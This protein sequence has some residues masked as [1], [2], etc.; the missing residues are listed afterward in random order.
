MKEGQDA[1]YYI[2][3]EDKEAL[4]RSPQLEGFKAKGVEVLLF[5]DAV[6]DFSSVPEFQEKPFKS[7]T[8]GG[9]D[10]NN[11]AKSDDEKKDE[12]KP[13]DSE[14]S[15][16]VTF[17]KLVLT[18]EVKDV[19]SSER[20]TDSPVCLVA[21]DHDIDMHLARVLKQHKQLDESAKRILELNPQHALIKGLAEAI[22]EDSSSALAEDA[23]H[24]LLDQARILEGETLPDPGGFSRRLA[25]V[26]EKGFGA[27]D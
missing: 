15:A 12:D 5:T 21:D 17:V 2:S 1:I 6:D 13:D 9:A 3:G 25:A 20:L 11:I 24:L 23:A 16:L 22:G 26:M 18:D 10:L 27:S 7:V 14:I 8:R 19:R 4:L